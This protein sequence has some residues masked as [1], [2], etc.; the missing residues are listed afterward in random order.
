MAYETTNS[1]YG[2]AAASQDRELALCKDAALAQ[3]LAEAD[4]LRYARAL[5]GHEQREARDRRGDSDVARDLGDFEL[6]KRIAARGF[7]IDA[8]RPSSLSGPH[9]GANDVS[10]ELQR[11]RQRLVDFGLR[12]HAIQGDG[13]CQFRALAHQLFSAQSRHGDVRTAVV[14]QLRK[15]PGHYRG[16][17]HEDYAVFIN[18]MA[19]AHEWGDHVTLQAAADA[20]KVKICLVTSYETRGFVSVTPITPG[21]DEPD[22]QAPKTI[23]LAF[24]AEVHYASID[25]SPQ[26]P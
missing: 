1:A 24:W 15:E 2:R 25:Q 9:P 12:E 23:W 7:R 10:H 13:A 11:L 5:D 18:R 21:L 4:D 16:F 26:S 14:S 20:Y 3:R 22:R 19:L 8:Q 6:A 17:V